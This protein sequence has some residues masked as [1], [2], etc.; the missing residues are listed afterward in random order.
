MR[1]YVNKDL[2]HKVNKVILPNFDGSRKMIAHAWLQ[3][4]NTYFTLS[5]MIEEDALQFSILHLEGTTHEWW[6]NGL[7]SLGHQ[8]I[9]S[10]QEF[11]QKLIK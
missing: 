8:N 10:Y 5:P 2:K 6:Y 9:N 7:L 3:K 1:R 11:S 4:L